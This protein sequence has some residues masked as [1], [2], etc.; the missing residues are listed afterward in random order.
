MQPPR[1]TPRKARNSQEPP[2]AETLQLVAGQT[3]KCEDGSDDVQDAQMYL[4][5]IEEQCE[6]LEAASDSPSSPQEA[7]SQS[8]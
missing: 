5:R 6:Q 3:D 2:G 1:R 8:E 4:S 7:S